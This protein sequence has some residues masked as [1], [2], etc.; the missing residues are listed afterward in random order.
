MPRTPYFKVKWSSF[1]LSIV[2]STFFFSFPLISLDP[3]H[4]RPMG[5]CVVDRNIYIKP[6]VKLLILLYSDLSELSF[7]V[8]MKKY[9]S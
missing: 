2:N 1:L 9:F 7:K 6:P 3:F 4:T 8:L 5:A